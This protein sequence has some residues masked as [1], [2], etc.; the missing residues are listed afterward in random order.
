MGGADTQVIKMNED[1]YSKMTQLKENQNKKTLILV[2]H[3][4]H[5]FEEKGALE[6]AS[7]LAAEWFTEKFRNK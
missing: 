1:A 5:L 4:T 7:Q 6:Q 2:P 3:A